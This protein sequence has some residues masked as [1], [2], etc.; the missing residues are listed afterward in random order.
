[1][2]SAR[3]P[4]TEVEHQMGA[5]KGESRGKHKVSENSGSKVAIVQVTQRTSAELHDGKRFEGRARNNFR[6]DQSD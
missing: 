4:P 6:V 3:L 5:A 1:M 2:M